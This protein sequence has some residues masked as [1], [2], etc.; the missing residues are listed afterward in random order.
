VR[1]IDL[2][3]EG[4]GKLADRRFSFAPGLTIV[5]GPNEAGKS[6]LVDAIVAV[7]YG[8][9]RKD[10]RD[11]RRPWSG[12]KYRGTLRY[13]LR[14]D[15]EYEIQ[16]DF[17]KDGRTARAFD[18]N[19]NDVTAELSVGKN[20]VP[21]EIHLGIPREVF[22]NASCVRQAAI[23]VEGD[24]AD[25]I[26]AALARALD[27]GPR[28]DAARRAVEALDGAL[29]LHVGTERATKNAPLRETLARASDLQSRADAA[30]AALRGLMETRE[31]LSSA[32]VER[33]R[34]LRLIAEHRRRARAMRAASLHSRLDQ[35]RKIREEIGALDAVRADFDDVADFPED[36]LPELEAR[37]LAWHDREMTAK[38]AAEEGRR[39][40]EAIGRDDAPRLDVDDETAAAAEL[41]SCE[42]EAARA[43]AVESANDAAEARRVPQ[44][45][46]IVGLSFVL[47]IPACLA[48]IGCAIAH[49]W[50]GALGASIIALF[51]AALCARRLRRRHAR[52]SAIARLQAQADDASSQ[53]RRAAAALAAIL[54]PLGIPSAEELRRR[55]ERT[56]ARAALIA[57]AHAAQERAHDA[58]AQSASA[59]A[60]F[61]T[62]AATMLRPS[63]SREQDVRA[64]RTLAARRR[65][66]DG[67]ENNRRMKDV[68]RNDLLRGDD[69]RGLETE[70]AELIA[71][72]VDETGI[73][74]VSAR[75]FEAE[76]AE[77]EQ[78]L[79]ETE[80]AVARCQAEIAS[81]ERALPDIAGLDDEAAA[82]RAQAARLGTFER[83]VKLARGTIE[84]RTREAHEKF[85][86]RLEDYA[87]TQLAFITAGRYSELRVDPTTLA[88]RVRAPETRHIVD[89]DALS[90][91]TRDQIYLIVRFAMARMFA[92]G[93]ETPP[94]LLDDPFAYWDAERLD[95]CLPV[96]AAGAATMQTIVCTSSREFAEAAG[97]LD[98]AQRIVL[99]S[100]VLV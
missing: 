88:V 44:S 13:V 95:R 93:L 19:G 54:T 22:V 42:V 7:L 64:A 8:P 6:T 69:E 73:A 68:L 57:A 40:S 21:G 5:S 41:A 39:A 58:L 18:R 28:E 83:A 89:L 48:A 85:A 78:L 59:A 100:P 66:R 29:R 43:Q 84:E 63:G 26:S 82:A 17:S 98:G 65:E 4:Y 97:A 33:E 1:L 46:S 49:L 27:G 96:L 94:L 11:A 56:R 90:A 92:E 30:R 31:R 99:D 91:G 77:L 62:L 74:Q 79:R 80:A 52:Q 50:T 12:A 15:R 10:D 53:E 61:D 87:V 75:A 25:R 20:V 45:D 3:L 34:L 47:A 76:G 81:A 71:E 67:I 24:H 2:E 9:G 86:R 70:L 72:G 60:A 16:R 37:Y 32:Q 51:F 35:L 36:L 23:A 38:L 55:S 14:D